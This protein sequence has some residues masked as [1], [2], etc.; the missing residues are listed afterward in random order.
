MNVSVKITIVGVPTLK[1]RVSSDSI[2]PITEGI[3]ETVVSSTI[4][5][6][7]VL[8]SPVDLTI[9]VGSDLVVYVTDSSNVRGID[10]EEAGDISILP[11]ST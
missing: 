1:V 6:L 9:L 3:R 2:F 8:G 5:V 11:V 10:E 4:S 7:V